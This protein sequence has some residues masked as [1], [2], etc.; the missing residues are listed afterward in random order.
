MNGRGVASINA[1]LKAMPFGM[2]DNL[3]LLLMFG[4]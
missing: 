3:L 2:P 1:I 4:F